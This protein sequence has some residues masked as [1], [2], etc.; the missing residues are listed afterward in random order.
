[1]GF[2]YVDYDTLSKYIRESIATELKSHKLDAKNL[3]KAL[4]TLSI[5]HPDRAIQCRY[6]LAVLNSLDKSSNLEKTCILNAA[7]FYIREQIFDSYQGTVTSFFLSPE[8]STLYNALTTSL[9]L[10]L[11]NFP[12]SKNLLDMYDALSKFMHEHV[13]VDSDP[14]KGYLDLSKQLFSSQKIKNYKVEKVL[15]DLVKKVANFKLEQIEQTREKQV[16]DSD[17][18]TKNRIGLFAE[19]TVSTSLTEVIVEQASTSTPP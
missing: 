17:K 5:R 13:Y 3:P 9:N 1:M 11:E 16:Q 7:A 19:K 4:R 14:R 6:L 18:K 15:Q 12:D 10:T 2:Q 8:N